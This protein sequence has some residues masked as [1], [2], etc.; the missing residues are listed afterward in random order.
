[1]SLPTT[2]QA[3]AADSAELPAPCLDGHDQVQW[4]NREVHPHGGQL[5]AHLRNSF[6]SIRDLDD[7]VQESY[8]RV[9]KAMAA[10]PI[11]SAKAFLFKVGRHIAL[12]L[13]RR[14]RIS[15]VAIAGDLALLPV[16]EDRLNAAEVLTEQEKISLVGDAIVALPAR[17]RAVI[18][19]HKIKGLSQAD[20]ARQLG[21]TEKAV[22][23]QVARGVQ[24][25]GDFLR[26]RGYEL[27]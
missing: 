7:V 9:W 25:C 5:K 3:S 6:P 24:L 18:I 2:S 10:R 19:L 11:Q 16:I 21:C 1:M 20:V 4:F 14:D 23:H 27:F 12:D 13:V 8:L 15:P 17:T 22:E 26:Q